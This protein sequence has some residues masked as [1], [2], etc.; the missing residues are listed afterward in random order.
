MCQLIPFRECRQGQWEGTLPQ[1]LPGEQ[2]LA[3]PFSHH[4]RNAGLLSCP[5]P[6]TICNDDSC[7]D[8]SQRQQKRPLLLL[9]APLVVLVSSRP[10]AS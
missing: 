9:G 4:T 10:P 2:L 8:V 3:T 7:F 5:S 1:L 6:M